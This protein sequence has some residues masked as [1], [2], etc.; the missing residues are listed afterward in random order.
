MALE[1]ALSFR[2]DG[3]IV[4]E[5]YDGVRAVVNLLRQ[6]IATGRIFR[7]GRMQPLRNKGGTSWYRA[8]AGCVFDGGD[9][10][11]HF[12]H[13]DLLALPGGRASASLWPQATA[14]LLGGLAAP[15]AAALVY[16][17][18]RYVIL[19]GL[20][21]NGSALYGYDLKAKRVVTVD[22]VVVR[23]WPNGVAEVARRGKVTG[24]PADIRPGDIIYCVAFKVFPSGSLRNGKFVRL[25][26]DKDSAKLWILDTSDTDA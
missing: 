24:C 23:V 13:F 3:W 25:R 17:R 12:P 10:R 6:P 15:R 11:W 19:R 5:K 20:S 14:A 18:R 8:A 1:E 22:C 9:G 26:S 2:R 16:Q 4:E 21:G 7:A